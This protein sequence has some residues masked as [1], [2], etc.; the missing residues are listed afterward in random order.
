MTPRQRHSFV[1]RH[2]GCQ[3]ACRRS[4]SEPVGTA[5]AA[6]DMQAVVAAADGLGMVT[7]HVV[8]VSRIG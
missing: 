5:I 3:A 6:I 2:F 1:L 7:H 8:A 4:R